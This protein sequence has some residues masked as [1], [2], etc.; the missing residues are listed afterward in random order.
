MRLIDNAA[1]WWK[2][3]SMQA[4]ALNTALLVSWQALP[5]TLQTI[6]PVSYLLVIAVVLLILGMVGRMVKQEN[7]NAVTE[8]KPNL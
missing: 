7:I 6:L 5:S 8:T 4:Q 1:S 3:F 2:M